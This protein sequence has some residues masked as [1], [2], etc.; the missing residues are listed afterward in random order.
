LGRL[1]RRQFICAACGGA[2]AVIG[3]YYLRDFLYAP[4]PKQIIPPTLRE[5]MHYEQVGQE[6]VLCKLCYRKCLIQQA[7]RGVCGTRE[8][9]ER[10][11][12]TLVHGRPA[13]IHLDPIEKLPL[14]HMSP[15]AVSLCA[16]SAGCNLHCLNCI[17]WSIALKPPEDVE[18]VSKSPAELVQMAKENGARI[19]AFTYNEPIMFYEYIYD[20]FKLAK[21]SGIKT[22]F[23]TNATMN[24]KPLED[25]SPYV[26]TVVADLK[27]FSNETYL[28][29]TSGEIEPVLR[30]LKDVKRLGLWL[31][32]VHLIIPTMTDDDQKIREMSTWIAS[33]LGAETPLHLSRFFP[34]YKL[35]KLS[36][37]PLNTM[38]KAYETAKKAGLKF[39][40]MGNVPGQGLADTNCPSCRHM[41]IQRKQFAVYC[42]NVKDGR[43]KYCGGPVAGAW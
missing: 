3:G 30:F 12:Y 42:N 16:G 33:E 28:K 26:D 9:R 5:A 4:T 19:I 27:A 22:C 39:V 13:A 2:V 25:L 6:A 40:Y 36:A 8:N 41:L 31:E 34:S 10:K 11:L 35:E 37:A 38:M 23:H 15:G 21:A 18:A 32:I 24:T 43:C 1:T 14:Y 7:G 17:N 20:V 29:L